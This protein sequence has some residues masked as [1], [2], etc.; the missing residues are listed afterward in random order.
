MPSCTR[1][2]TTSEAS[3]G[4]SLWRS[5]PVSGRRLIPVPRRSQT[6]TEPLTALV[7]SL[8][9]TLAVPAVFDPESA[10]Y[11]ISPT[12]EHSALV[13]QNLGL[14]NTISGPSLQGEAVDLYTNSTPTARYTPHAF[15]TLY[16]QPLILSGALSTMCLRNNLY[17]NDTRF[18]EPKLRTSQVTFGAYPVIPKALDSQVYDGQGAYEAVAQVVGHNPEECEEAIESNDA[19][20]SQ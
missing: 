18:M 9:G 5:C 12:G 1:Y 16:N 4:I 14:F 19:F 7:G 2:R 15:H 10:A 6:L 8:G 20:A 13:K 3:T 17:F 11:T